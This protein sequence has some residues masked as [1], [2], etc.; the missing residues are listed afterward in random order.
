MD[1]AAP[2]ASPA[3]HS[4]I[5]R[6]SSRAK[7]AEAMRRS[8]PHLPAEARGIVESML[9]PETIG[10]IAGTLIVWTGSH[11]ASRAQRDCQVGTTDGYGAIKVYRDQFELGYVTISQL[12]AEG[13]AIG[14]I[15]LGGTLF[16]VSI[17]TGPIPDRHD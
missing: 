7:I 5:A 4:N 10:I 1:T 6:Q 2:D 13:T 16:R 8:L 11:F 3:S 9:R 15:T 12:A 14:T 17:S